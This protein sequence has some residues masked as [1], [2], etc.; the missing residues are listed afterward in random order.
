MA[1]GLDLRSEVEIGPG[2]FT[3]ETHGIVFHVTGDT[4]ENNTECAIAKNPFLSG[5]GA[6]AWNGT[7]WLKTTIRRGLCVRGPD[8]NGPGTH[9]FFATNKKKPTAKKTRITVL[10][11]SPLARSIFGHR[12]GVQGAA[13]PP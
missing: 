11:I 6:R 3:T 12:L 2:L 1:P 8:P 9:S 13:S 5:T 10:S 4:K 7:G